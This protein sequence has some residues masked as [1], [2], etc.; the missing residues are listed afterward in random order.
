MVIAVLAA[1]TIV[2]AAVMSMHDDGDGSTQYRIYIGLNDRDT[3]TQL[4]SVE[5]AK[6]TLD[7]ICDGRVDGYTI[8]VFEGVWT[9]DN[10]DRIR[11]TS[12]ICVFDG[13]D[14]DTIHRI[15]DDLRTSLNQASILIESSEVRTECYSGS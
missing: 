10:G 2:S 15:C 7:R 14:V 11:E 13:T 8:Q 9:D 6:D 1:P 5:D 12:L 4:V 3:G